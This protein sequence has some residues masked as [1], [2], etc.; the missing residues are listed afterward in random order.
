MRKLILI[1]IIIGLFF[2]VFPVSAQAMRFNRDRSFIINDHT[3]QEEAEGKKIYDKLKKNLIK[4]HQLKNEDYQ[5]LG[6]YFMGQ[7]TGKNHSFMNQMMEKMMG[8]EGERLA[9]INLGKKLSGCVNGYQYLPM[10][11]M[12]GG[13]GYWPMGWFFGAYWLVFSLLVLLVLTLT[14]IYLYKKIKNEDRRK[15]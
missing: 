8:K 15:R 14:A 1:T 2:L 6:E 4:C 9:H 3:K 13:Y 10:M 7:M 11:G 5:A 12:M